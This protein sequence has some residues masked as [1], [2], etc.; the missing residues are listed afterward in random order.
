MYTIEEITIQKT[1]MTSSNS[2]F[3]PH[4]FSIAPMMDWSDRH[5]RYLWRLISANTRLYTEMITTGALLHGE[6]E[7]F[8]AY[9]A[10]EHPLAIQLGGSDPTDLA[11]CALLAE[12][13]GYDEVN[14]NCGCPSDRVQNGMI[15]ACLMAYPNKVAEAYQAMQDSVEIEVT[16]K[17]RIGIDDMDDYQGMVDFIT[18][19]AEKGCKTFIV[20]AR[21]AWLKGLSPKE[22]RDIPPL[23]YPFVHRL[24]N[25]FPHLN[26]VINGGIKTLDETLDHLSCVDGVMIGREAYSN[27]YLLAEVDQR[28]FGESHPIATRMEVA[29]QYIQY[30]Q[31]EMVKGQ[32]LNHMS[33]HV[34]G[35]FQGVKGARAFRRHISENAHKK[36]ASVDV[37]IDALKYIE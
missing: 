16:I 27:P 34:L 24:K 3:Q 28:I 29:Q 33:R 4:R 10:E 14:L 23:E 26:I 32:R 30:C 12:Q 5:C 13:W 7:R 25:E 18:P 9:N 22:N 31:Q 37:L 17:H 15:G 36:N 20:H 11:A 35:L 6:P 19:I 8:L 21:K 1:H 2:A